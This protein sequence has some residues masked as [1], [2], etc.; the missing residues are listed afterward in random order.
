MKNRGLLKLV[1]ALLAGALLAGLV[2]GCMIVPYGD[3]P[4]QSHEHGDRD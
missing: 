1:R 4:A 3:M 2:A